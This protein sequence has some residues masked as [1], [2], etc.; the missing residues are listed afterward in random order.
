MSIHATHTNVK[1]HKREATQYMG[2]PGICTVTFVTGDSKVTFS[3]LKRKF[4]EVL[5]ANPWLGGT[6]NKEKELTFSTT[7]TSEMVD[8]L[9]VSLPHNPSI[10]RKVPYQVLIKVIAKDPKM[11]VQSGTDTRK[12]GAPI[13][14][15]VVVDPA[16]NSS[17]FAIIFSLSHAAA[18]GHD[19]YR[20]FNMRERGERSGER[21]EAD[22]G[23]F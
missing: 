8:S 19:Y 4:V 13:S 12:A 3:S 23:A 15:L 10:T 22:R 2:H 20:I 18:D 21:S 6:F 5:N 1:L 11:A 14:K 17:S 9:I 7:P 16:A